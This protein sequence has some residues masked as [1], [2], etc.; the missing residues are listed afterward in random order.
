MNIPSEIHWEITNACN[1]FCKTCIQQSGKPRINELDT[2]KV[3]EILRV[4]QSNVT[5]ICFTGGEPFTRSDFVEILKT[6]FELGI[7]TEVITNGDYLTQQIINSLSE[8]NISLGISLDGSTPKTND[9]IRGVGSFTKTVT[10]IKIAV[11]NN[12]PVHIYTTVMRSNVSELENIALMAK[13]LGCQGIH[14]SEVTLAG[15][16]QSTSQVVPLGLKDHKELHLRIDTI[17][18]KI[19][20]ENLLHLDEQCWI[21]PDSAWYIRSDGEIYAC[22]EIQLRRPEKSL[23]NVLNLISNNS[24]IQELSQCNSGLSCSYD[25]WASEHVTLIKNTWNVCPLTQS[26]DQIQTLQ[27]FYRELDSFY[28][29]IRQ[30][31][32]ECSDPDCMGYIW[33]LPQEVE[34]LINS[35]VPIVQINNN[36][37]FLHSFETKEDDSLEVETKYPVCKFVEE[38]CRRCTI[39]QNRPMVCRL[40]PLGLET[41]NNKPVLALHLDC[42]FVRYLQENNLV[43]EFKNKTHNLIS[44]LSPELKKEIVSTY[45]AVDSIT[46]YPD[47]ENRYITIEEF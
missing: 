27:E 46:K 20:K 19:F 21:D 10:S 9:E 43:L 24:N 16:A 3:K 36:I 41:C 25:V 14:F 45:C 37:H 44:R 28:P 29:D 40:W 47:G 1:R 35:N 26:K 12:I 13:D 23:G 42:L 32:A 15:R 31:C 7:S 11:A 4:F 34:N 30:F 33:V 22:T 5:K 39:Y 17:A 18:T 6:T 8:Y 38:S 2:Q